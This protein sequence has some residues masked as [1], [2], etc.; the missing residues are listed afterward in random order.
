MR[1]RLALLLFFI[2]CG[3]THEER[4]ARAITQ[5]GGSP[6]KFILYSIDP[7]RSEDE[8]VQGTFMSWNILGRTE[9]A[10]PDEQRALARALA[11][12]AR[13]NADVA[14]CFEPRHGLHIEQG[15]RTVDFL[16]CFAC[17]QVFA[18]GFGVGRQFA[19]SR[20]PQSTFDEALRRHH[21]PLAPK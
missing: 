18:E 15:G 10:D 3:C 13:E 4:V 20:S 12:G 5:L 9:I 14:L 21:L 17:G 11:R 2:L 6:S 19:T 16:I 8:S 1:N 7:D